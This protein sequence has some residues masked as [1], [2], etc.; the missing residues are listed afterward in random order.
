MAW[1]GARAG[2]RSLGLDLEGGG[3]VGHL[4]RRHRAPGGCQ[5]AQDAPAFRRADGHPGHH[6]V[7]ER[8]GQRGRRELAPCRQQLLDHERDP[9]GALD[10][11]E[12]QAGGGPFALDPLD[13]R[14][15]VVA[16]QRRQRQSVDQPRHGRDRGEIVGPRVVAGDDVGLVG[17]HDREALVVGD[18]DEEGD[19][20]PGR[21]IGAMQV[22]EDQRHGPALAEAT[23]D[24]QDPFEGARLAAL[25]RRRGSR[26]GRIGRDAIGEVRQQA[27][28]LAA[29]RAPGSRTA[30]DRADREARTRSH[31]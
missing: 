21:G 6:Q 10:G 26:T 3:D 5:Q 29:T 23:E 8:V 13:Q 30:R 9:A 25:R 14:G 4:A 24:P 1:G 28:E 18:A 17:H 12:Q 20:R 7:I 16:V 22:L 19:E 27:E 31:G 15:E 2:G 11:Q